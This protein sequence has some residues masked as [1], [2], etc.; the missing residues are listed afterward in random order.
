MEIPY[1]AGKTGSNARWAHEE[2]LKKT[3]YSEVSLGSLRTDTVDSRWRRWVRGTGCPPARL[4]TPC[5]SHHPRRSLRV[6]AQT[7]VAKHC[8]ISA[9][10]VYPPPSSSPPPR[11]RMTHLP[12]PRSLVTQSHFRVQQDFDPQEGGRGA[13]PWGS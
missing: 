5:T 12:P 9:P 4:S 1:G 3:S 11:A 8:I 7:P 2:L 13:V 6:R 10:L